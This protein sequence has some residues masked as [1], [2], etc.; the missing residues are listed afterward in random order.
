M[1]RR[2]DE[3]LVEQGLASHIEEARSLIMAGNAVADDKRIDKAGTMVDI[4]AAI[5]LKGEKLPFVSRGG[6]KLQGA[7]DAFSLNMKNAA[8]LDIGASTGGFTDAALQAGAD[9]VFALDVGKGLIH[10]KLRNHPK[11]KLLEGINFREVTF[12]TVGQKVD[13]V[14]TDVS[15][16]SLKYIIPEVVQFCRK[17]SSFI[18]LVKPQFEARREEVGEGGIVRDL[19]VALRVCL[20]IVGFAKTKGFALGGFIKSPITGRKGNVEYLAYLVYDNVADSV[21]YDIIERVIC[22]KC[23]VDSQTERR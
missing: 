9:I 4:T 19:D 10:N 20:D 14:V 23:G 1:K 15:F 13:F 3:L 8:V 2:I 6:F 11:V 16:I 21:S 7:I 22:E 17:G 18:C 5:R 12:E